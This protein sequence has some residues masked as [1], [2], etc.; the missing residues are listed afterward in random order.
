[1]SHVD[2]AVA[3]AEDMKNLA[4]IMNQV[5]SIMGDEPSSQLS[6]DQMHDRIKNLLQ[7]PYFTECLGRLEYKAE[8]VWGLSC[9][10]RKMVSDARKLVNR[11]GML[12]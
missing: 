2:E 9:A 6:R 8:P 7:D 4:N 12:A 11:Q 10:E 1:M 3:H 5:K